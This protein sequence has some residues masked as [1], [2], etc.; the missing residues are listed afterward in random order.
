MSADWVRRAHLELEV[1]KNEQPGLHLNA[2]N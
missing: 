1:E 2:C